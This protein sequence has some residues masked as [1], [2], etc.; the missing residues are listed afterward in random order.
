MLKSRDQTNQRLRA[1]MKTFKE[2]LALK[3]LLD[4]RWLMSQ[5]VNQITAEFIRAQLTQQRLKPKG[6]RYNAIMKSLGLALFKRSPAQYNVFSKI[7]AMPQ[8]QTLN[9]VST[10]FYLMRAY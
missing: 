4:V 5:G 10:L 3:R 6:R 8:R 1:K 9:N 2:N 7:F